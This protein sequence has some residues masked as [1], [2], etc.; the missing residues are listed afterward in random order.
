MKLLSLNVRGTGS[1]A[2]RRAT[3]SV[4]CKVNPD[5]IVLQEIKKDMVDRCFVASIWRSRFKEWAL[6]PA[7]GRSG[8]ILVIWK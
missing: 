1:S 7:V 4:V 3:K 5:I 2:K 8:E 6:L